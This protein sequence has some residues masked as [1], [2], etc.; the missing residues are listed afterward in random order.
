M[1]ACVQSP[2]PRGN[3]FRHWCWR[4]PPCSIPA[5]DWSLYVQESIFQWGWFSGYRLLPVP[6]P[7]SWPS[8]SLSTLGWAKHTPSLY[9]PDFCSRFSL[10]IR[11][12]LFTSHS[13]NFCHWGAPWEIC[14]GLLEVEML[15]TMG[16]HLT[17]LPFAG[18]EEAQARREVGQLIDLDVGH[19]TFLWWSFPYEF[20][21][22]WSNTSRC[23]PDLRAYACAARACAVAQWHGILVERCGSLKGNPCSPQLFARKCILLCLKGHPSL[24]QTGSRGMRLSTFASPVVKSGCFHLTWCLSCKGRQGLQNLLGLGLFDGIKKKTT[25]AKP[26]SILIYLRQLRSLE[27]D[28]E[29]DLLLVVGVVGAP[30]TA[31][32]SPH[33]PCELSSR[34]RAEVCPYVNGVQFLGQINKRGV[35]RH[36][37]A[38]VL[39]LGGDL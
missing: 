17:L 4:F 3:S 31:R 34:K 19:L 5:G 16:I 21:G 15:W 1:F 38:S 10:E 35:L 29:A 27:G 13:N 8:S 20:L 12:H 30:L 9:E 2:G 18:D 28:G 25:R 23:G 39:E 11:K 33:Q 6:S 37:R 26:G 14:I 24:C 7:F 22:A 32:G 36:G